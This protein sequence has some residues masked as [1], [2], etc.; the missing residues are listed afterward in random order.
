[1]LAVG[2]VFGGVMTILKWDFTKL[3][4]VKYE[5]NNYE[6]HTEFENISIITNTSDIIFLPS[7]HDKTEINCYE[8]QKS[9]HS[10]TSKDK[11]LLIE[12]V[13]ERKWYDYID[14]HVGSPKITVSLPKTQYDSLTIKA[15]TGDINL[16]TSFTFE[17]INISVSTGDVKCDASA[18]G[19]IAIKTST[20]DVEMKGVSASSLSVSLSSGDVDIKDTTV[21]GDITVRVSTG[22][23]ALE[24]VRCQNLI[25]TGSTGDI[26][27]KNVIATENFSIERSTGDVYFVDSDANEIF[28]ETSSGDVEGTLLSDKVFITKTSSGDVNVPESTTG[29]KCKITTSSGDI[30]IEIKE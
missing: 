11:T 2:I 14:F 15:S 28:V 3:S 20:G 27:L 17:N 6:L 10:V 25:S 30:S 9:K 16:S 13:D 19:D 1:L 29:G 7:E 5:T 22:D 12:V 4:T 8:R 26:S 18:T 21:A 23:V 24:N